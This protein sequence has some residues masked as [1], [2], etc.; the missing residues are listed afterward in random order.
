MIELAN[1]NF[2]FSY[3]K[4]ATV[5]NHNWID[6]ENEIA[7]V[8][9]TL[10]RNRENA[11]VKTDGSNRSFIK[12]ENIGDVY[13]LNKLDFLVRYRIGGNGTKYVYIKD[14]YI[15]SEPAGSGNYIINWAKISDELA[16]S[17][18]ELTE[19]L[20][21]YLRLFVEAPLGNL[22][23]K[24]AIPKDLLLDCVQGGTPIPG[25]HEYSKISSNVSIK[26]K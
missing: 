7:Q 3:L 24:N 14:N 17:L 19:M 21:L 11:K 9:H 20:S 15:C 18:N 16:S 6:F 22:I 2:W 12:L 13:V 26:S 23:E 25:R 5:T 1:H 8:I 10:E 4:D